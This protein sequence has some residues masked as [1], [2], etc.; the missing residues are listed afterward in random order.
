[1]SHVT[2]LLALFNGAKHLDA[3]LKS[4]A[5][6]SFADW[7]LMVSDDGSQDDG[8]AMVRS[9]GQGRAVRLMDGPRRGYAANFLHL[10]ESVGG[11]ADFVALSDQDDVW[12]DHKLAR[13]VSALQGLD[14]PA[15]Y[16][17]RT[18]IVGP[19]L[20]DRGLS[21]VWCKPFGFQNALVQNVA[22]GNTIVLNQS[23]L[24][25]A[26]EAIRR[27]RN[28]GMPGVMV[29]DWWLYQLISGAGG[30]VIR[31][32]EPALLY[33]QHAGN[34]IGENRSALAKLRRLKMVMSGTFQTWN[35]NN[36]AA[37][38]AAGDLLTPTARATLNDFAALRNSGRVGKLWGLWQ[39][40]L[41]RQTL[42]D[43]AALW[44]SALI[45]RI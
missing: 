9:F 37:M 12:L 29:H 34:L 43:H 36:I 35:Q 11:D 10:I 33:R 18:R 24:N 26:Q 39:S 13:A 5:D 21:P 44:F 41:Y 42:T 28:A 30:Q 38:Q 16:C 17:A 20:E 45:G 19:E 1:M 32:T 7:S 31:D 3:Q 25:L 23:A 14:G 6:Q 15:L 22:A 27:M 2:I 4:Y 8:P 40:G